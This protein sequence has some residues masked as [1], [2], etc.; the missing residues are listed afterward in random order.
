MQVIKGSSPF[1]GGHGTNYRFTVLTDGL[2][3]YEWSPDGRFEDRQSSFA[4]NRRLE[5]PDY[6]VRVSGS[7]LEIIT[8]RFHLTYNKQEFSSFGL[9]ALVLEHT[10]SLWRYGENKPWE[11]LGGT[12]R[13]LD[14]VDG[15]IDIGTG[16]MSEK[17][18]ATIDDSSSMLF[19]DGFVASRIPGRVD[20]YLFAYGHDYRSCI[21][22]F[23]AVSGPTPLLPRWALG[24]WWSRNHAYSADSYLE[25]V[26]K[27]KEEKIPLSV[28]VLDMDWHLVEDA[29]VIEAKQTGWTGY[30]WNRDLFPDPP[31]LLRQ[32]HRRGLMTALN[33]HPA[34]GIHSYEDMYEKL[35]TAVGHDTSKKEP[36]SF[37]VSNRV[38]FEA[39]FDVLLASLE[40]D[41]CDFWWIDWQQ[42]HHSLVQNVDPLFMLN[43]FNF[44][45]NAKR[46]P[47]RHPIVFSRYAGPGSHRYPIGFS[48]DT[49]VSWES[50]RFQPEFT[51]TASN[52]GYGWWSHDIGGHMDGI[53]N[54]ELTVRWIQLGVFSPIMRLHST[55]SRWVAKEPWKLDHAHTVA[56]FM[57]L[58]HRLIPY[59]QTMNARSALQGLPLV[60]PLYW[61]WPHHPQAYQ[62]R[63]HYLFGSEILVIPITTPQ[64][65]TVRLAKTKAWLPPGRWVDFFTG[66]VYNGDQTVWLCRPKQRYPVFLKEGGIVPLDGDC[67][68]TN[69]GKNPHSVE[70]VLAAGDVDG[71]FEM[72]EEDETKSQGSPAVQVDW[73]K[74]LIEYKVSSQI[75]TITSDPRTP[76]REWSILLLGPSDTL[77]PSVRAERATVK[78]ISK[79]ANG[80]LLELGPLGSGST[81]IELQGL[82]MGPNTT[83]YRLAEIERVIDNARIAYSLKESIWE[84]VQSLV[85]GH[86]LS[87]LR[88]LST[89]EMEDDLRYAIQEYLVD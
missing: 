27:F 55:K 49:I 70:V 74:T 3:R 54:E 59:L 2:L 29:R 85:E 75:L 21:Q 19:E 25:L 47:D 71:R 78:R 56:T 81:A 14:A 31:E 39:Y 65:P 15:R 16:L 82:K 89:V 6:S 63:N 23:Y 60:Q 79:E 30:S 24:N 44:L 40:D 18:Y 69:G 51:A 1:V 42:G 53:K 87:V 36:I 58:R 32:L 77:Q 64:S 88:R 37:D 13:T 26:D 9:F 46:Y 61:E 50:L 68:P 48:G 28:G 11:N 22:A 62:H 20:G 80:T 66:R 5:V 7:T 17:G 12:A 10:R 4:V 33:D 45:H 67:A 43:H 41:G 76:S 52:V 73:V 34:D 8:S 86:T 57:R 83:R 35:A 72:L 38:F 84:V